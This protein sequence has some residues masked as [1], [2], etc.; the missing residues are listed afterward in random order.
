MNAISFVTCALM[1]FV[2]TIALSP[3][4]DAQIG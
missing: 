2:A 1:L 3:I 4:G